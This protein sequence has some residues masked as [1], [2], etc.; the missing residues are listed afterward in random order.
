[1]TPE[2]KQGRRATPL[3]ATRKI[4]PLRAARTDR[5]RTVFEHVVDLARD[6]QHIDRPVSIEIGS[7]PRAGGVLYSRRPLEH[8]VDDCHDVQ[9][10][11][12]TV[13]VDV[14]LVRT[15]TCPAGVTDP[16]VVS[17]LLAGIVGA[18]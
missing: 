13:A 18:C 5:Q 4:M 6:I 17:I 11:D 12:G 1:V 16:V 10:V 2:N 3:S 8:A 9:H 14:I 15:E 7:L